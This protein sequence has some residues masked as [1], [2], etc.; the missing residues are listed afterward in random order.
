MYPRSNQD[1]RRRLER[2]QQ[3]GFRF[4]GKLTENIGKETGGKGFR[5]NIPDF[6]R[7][8]SHISA[9]KVFRYKSGGLANGARERA[10]TKSFLADLNLSA[11]SKVGTRSM[12]RGSLQR[13]KISGPGSS[14][15]G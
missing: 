2:N 14:S 8:A 10:Y 9:H 5:I 6:G 11:E 13:K 12:M 15:A 1:V 4:S 7:P 3:N